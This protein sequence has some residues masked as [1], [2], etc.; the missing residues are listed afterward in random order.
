[1]FSPTK[2]RHKQLLLEISEMIETLV[3]YG[4]IEI[5]EGFIKPYE[6]YENLIKTEEYTKEDE[7]YYR[8]EKILN[9]RLC[10]N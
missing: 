8:L 2:H 10:Q 4:Y 6:Y 7:S 9:D 3:K 5:A 1:M